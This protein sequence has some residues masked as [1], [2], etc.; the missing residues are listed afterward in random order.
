[1][2]AL[3]LTLSREL[4]KRPLGVVFFTSPT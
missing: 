1:M 2:E 3:T 4:K